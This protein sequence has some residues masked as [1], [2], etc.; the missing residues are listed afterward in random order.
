MDA[1]ESRA[2]LAL[3][4][5]DAAVE[6]ATRAVQTLDAAHVP[7]LAELWIL[8]AHALALR[9]AAHPDADDALTTLRGRV[10]SRL[11]ELPPAL[12]AS[13]RTRPELRAFD[14]V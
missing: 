6:I 2:R 11:A 7:N 8:G 4:E 5:L 14:L 10:A 9:E 1:T 3:G 13:Y 12:A